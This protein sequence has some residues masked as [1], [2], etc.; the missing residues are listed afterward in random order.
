M[1]KKLVIM[2][3]PGSREFAESLVDR[4]SVHAD[5]V[6][7]QD[8]DQAVTYPLRIRIEEENADA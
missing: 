8:V 7:V 5:S 6:T 3:S 1:A 4:L 2:A